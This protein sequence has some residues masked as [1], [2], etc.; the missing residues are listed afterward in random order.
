[1]SLQSNFTTTSIY[2]YYRLKD[3]AG[4]T[5]NTL[6]DRFWPQRPP[7]SIAYP[8]QITHPIMHERVMYFGPDTVVGSPT[9]R[10]NVRSP[11]ASGTTRF[12]A[13]DS[14]H[15]PLGEDKDCVYFD[16]NSYVGSSTINFDSN[17]ATGA[18][19]NTP[20][21]RFR[22]RQPPSPVAYSSQITRPRKWERVTYF[23]PGTVVDGATVN[24]RSERASG[25][26][27]G[28]KVVSSRTPCY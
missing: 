21:N 9:M 6:E 18:R 3:A 23:G 10:V 12:L 8:P 2:I 28:V 26:V 1:M 7:S 14:P 11:R 20:K 19:Y 27:F 5:Y 13:Q 25:A 17:N 15:E 24:I 22:P 4:A 16:S